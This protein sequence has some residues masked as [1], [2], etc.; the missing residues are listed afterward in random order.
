MSTQGNSVSCLL[1][2]KNGEDYLEELIP[3]ILAM[4]QLEDE[5]IIVNDGS[6][7]QTSRIIENCMVNDNRI[8]LIQT[9]GIGLVSAL[10]LG[11]SESINPWIAR[12]DVDDV[13]DPD[14]LS[15]QR[16][17]INDS[18][19][20]IFS[21]YSFTTFSGHYLGTVHS[22]ISE[23]ATL[24][25]LV[26]AQRTPHPVSLINRQILL[27]AGGYSLEEYPAEDLG[28]W[29]RMSNFGKLVS[30]PTILLKYRLN[31]KS[32]SKL[33]REKQ[34]LK[35]DHLIQNW[36]GWGEV[37]DNCLSDI[38]ETTALYL[39]LE[40]GYERILLHLRELKIVSTVL[41]KP[42]RIRHLFRGFD[43]R[44]KLGLVGAAI[45]VIYWLIVRKIY[46]VLQ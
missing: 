9:E 29:L 11:V 4:L 7:D 8:R 36:F 39:H 19:A 3:T 14:R 21:D 20:V 16:L 34:L 10:N 22:A 41:A 2:V 18:I 17:L 43:F 24:L 38:K 40:G 23:R 25:S 13:Y 46:R 35:K 26:S 5:V 12:F 44:V 37:Y 32:V 28:L 6:T 27:A 42:L 45:K 15:I 30:T 31:G 33:N 1:P